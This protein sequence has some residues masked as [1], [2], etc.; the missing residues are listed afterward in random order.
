M[1]GIILAGGKGTRLY[2]MTK[3]TNKHLLPVY[4]KPMI[5]YPLSVFMLAGIYD[6]LIITKLE[7]IDKFKNVLG[8]GSQWGLS[9]QYAP[10]AEPRGL[11]EAFIIGENFIGNEPVALL[12]GDNILYKDAFQSMLK[13]A[14]NNPTGAHIFAYHVADPERFGV[15]EIDE[16]DKAVSLEEKPTN[17][18]S[19]YAV[20]GMYFYD[21]QVVE[22]A[23]KIKPSL[24]GELEITDVNK[25]YLEKG[26]LKAQKLGRGAA[27]LD[28]G[29]PEALLEASQFIHMIEKRQG[30]KIADLDQIARDKKLI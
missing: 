9:I 6:I 20:I 24:R 26:Q 15:V 4:D 19:S 8:D 29:R 5:Y 12:L 25:V 17:P 7:D 27:W 30:L 14:Q 23:K 28:V 21:N 2:P 10:Q 11:A 22:I 3:V 1:K 16:N 13:D 18:K